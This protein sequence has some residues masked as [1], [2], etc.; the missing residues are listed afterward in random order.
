MD[1]QGLLVPSLILLKTTPALRFRLF[2]VYQGSTSC[3]EGL[4][5]HTGLPHSTPLTSEV[6]FNLRGLVIWRCSDSLCILVSLSGCSQSS[7][8]ALGGYGQSEPSA[9]R[10]RVTVRLVAVGRMQLVPLA[11]VLQKLSLCRTTAP[12][13]EAGPGGPLLAAGCE[14]S[15]AGIRRSVAPAAGF[16]MGLG[17]KLGPAPAGLDPISS[18]QQFSLT[19]DRPC[20]IL[21]PG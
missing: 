8:Q 19:E 9:V 16:H 13:S 18:P 11:H 3:Q 20:S 2:A 17:N 5:P 15:D 4:F 7:G 6:F 21:V 10:G 12:G 14:S 1:T